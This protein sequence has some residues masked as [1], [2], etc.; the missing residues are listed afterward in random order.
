MTL[1]DAVK[2]FANEQLDRAFDRID[3]NY[4]SAL[5]DIFLDYENT[6]LSVVIY[7]AVQEQGFLIGTNII[8]NDYK[9]G[10]IFIDFYEDE[11]GGLY[12]HY[13]GVDLPPIINELNEQLRNV[14]LI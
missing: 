4:L 10:H 6:R 7:D 2:Q 13:E 14:E 1:L 3:G 8:A 5:E 11:Q 12:G 9:V